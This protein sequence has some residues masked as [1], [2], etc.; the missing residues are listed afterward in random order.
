MELDTVACRRQSLS[1]TESLLS[2]R[3]AEF[4]IKNLCFKYWKTKRSLGL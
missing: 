4:N 3:I 1:K 2:G